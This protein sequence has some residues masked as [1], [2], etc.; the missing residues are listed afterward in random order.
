MRS[1]S[2]PQSPGAVP[3]LC[4]RSWNHNLYLL[5]VDTFSAPPIDC[6]RHVIVFMACGH[7]EIHEF[8]IWI[9][10]AMIFWYGPPDRLLRYMSYPTICLEVLAFHDS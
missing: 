6:C 7:R 5:R 1:V 3:R 4:G 9:Q 10:S 2:M 8:C